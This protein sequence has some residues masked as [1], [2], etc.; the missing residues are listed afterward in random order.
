M[1]SDKL[2][3]SLSPRT[4]LIAAWLFGSQAKGNARP[5]SDVDVAVLGYRRLTL[6][7]RLELQQIVEQAAGTSSAD[8]VDLRNASPIL[9]FEAL[10]GQRLVVN[11][12]ERLAE[13]SSIVGREYES[14]MA[15]LAQG[16]RARAEAR[17]VLQPDRSKTSP[18]DS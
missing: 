5:D 3:E 8:L 14:D 1:L 2:R 4:E 7:E 10:H 11:S 9:A 12:P 18:S 17:R 15:L 16:F 6:D 13:F